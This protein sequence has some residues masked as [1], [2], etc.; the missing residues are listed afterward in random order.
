MITQF[1]PPPSPRVHSMTS[2]PVVDCY[3]TMRQH[4]KCYLQMAGASGR[5][6]L[7]EVAGS[8]VGFG[9]KGGGERGLVR[10]G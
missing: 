8:L 5:N 6:E 7:Q 3:H 1:L 9:G 10:I 4:V 2:I